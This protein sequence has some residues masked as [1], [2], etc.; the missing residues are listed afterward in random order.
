[1]KDTGII[2][3]KKNERL[4]HS[5]VFFLTKTKYCYTLKLLKL[6]YFLDFSHFKETGKSITGLDYFAWKMGPV[7]TKLYD[8]IK[9]DSKQTKLKQFFNIIKKGHKEGF[10]KEVIQLQPKVNFNE[11]LFS[12]RQLKIMNKLVS[13]YK[14]VKAN[15]MILASHERKEPWDKVFNEEGRKHEKIPYEYALDDTSSSI[16]K[17]FYKELSNESKEIEKVF[18]SSPSVNIF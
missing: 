15:D 16:S 1:M 11:N 10:D 6:L 14:S 5:M 4:V 18:G 17:D 12:K 8:A 13:T 9:K 2:I 7:P 3:D